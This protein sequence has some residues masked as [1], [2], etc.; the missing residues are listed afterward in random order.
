MENETQEKVQP[1][2]NLFNS[3]ISLK[4]WPQKKENKTYYQVS[5]QRKYIKNNEEVF[6]TMHFFPDVLLPLAELLREAYGLLNS[7]KQE[8]RRQE[9]ELQK[10]WEN[11]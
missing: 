1:V 9:K 11:A 2:I 4:V 3:G 6:E 7:Y 8:L 5:I 10:Q